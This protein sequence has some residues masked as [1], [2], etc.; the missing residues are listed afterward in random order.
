[1]PFAEVDLDAASEPAARPS[2]RTALQT[3]ADVLAV[4]QEQ[5]LALR[6]DRE[7]RAVERARAIGYLAGVALKAIEAGDMLA[8]IE[9]LEAV[10]KERDG[11]GVR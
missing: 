6:V 4:L 10:L 2:C 1:M 5:V 7:A 9:A 11:E 8:R 3:P